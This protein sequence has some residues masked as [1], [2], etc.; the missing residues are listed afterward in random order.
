MSS[1]PGHMGISEGLSLVVFTTVSTMFLSIW[2][3]SIDRTTT[4]TWMTPLVNGTVGIIILLLLLYVLKNTSVDLYS[5]CQELLGITATRLITLYYIGVY[6]LEAILLLRQLAEN[7][8]LT[9]LPELPFE[10]AIGWYTIAVITLVYI[11][12]EPIARASYIILPLSGF[13]IIVVLLLLIPQYEFLYLTP[14]KGAGLD[15]V[16]FN[17]VMSSGIN[18]GIL[19]PIFLA[20]SFQNTKTIKYSV[21]YGLGISVFL[22]TSTL[23]AFIAAFGT[24]SAREKV[25][26]FYELSRLVYIN[27]YIQRIESLIILLWSISGILNIAIVFYIG[28]YLIGRLFKLPNLKPLIIPVFIILSALAMLPNDITSVNAFHRKAYS[29]LYNIGVLI[30]PVILFAAALFHS[31]KNRAKH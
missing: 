22:K 9:A 1:E 13:V 28:L 24:G 23:T 11:G 2:S 27:R 14:W 7:T 10:I 16:L 19:I 12:I 8:L 29:G 5:A 30:I 3:Q 4:A 18:L 20:R 15:K 6:F 17:G 26:P 25:L 21:L 31:L